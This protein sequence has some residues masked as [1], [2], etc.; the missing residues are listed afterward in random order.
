MKYKDGKKKDELKPDSVG[1]FLKRRK[2]NGKKSTMDKLRA[3]RLK[4]N[5]LS[6]KSIGK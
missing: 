1:A 4:L 2:K 5:K 3:N 6:P